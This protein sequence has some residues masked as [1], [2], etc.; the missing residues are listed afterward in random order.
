MVRKSSQ[1]ELV[2]KNPS[3]NAEELRDV[4]LIPGLGRYPGE[5]PGNPL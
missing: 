1:V 3:A 4:D 2:V 5:G